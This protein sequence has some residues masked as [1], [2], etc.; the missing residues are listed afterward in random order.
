MK[1]TRKLTITSDEFFDYLENQL[2]KIANE[3]LEDQEAYT[4]SDIQEGFQI[5]QSTNTEVNKVELFINKY[6]RGSE[7]AA[8]AT[9]LTDSY[10]MSYQVKP[11]SD[12]IEVVY[13]QINLTNPSPAKSGFFAKFGE[14]L[15]LSRMSNSLYDVQN[16]IIKSRTH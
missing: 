6:I 16:A 4:N 2:L 12:G 10:S 8:T 15:Y 9:S 14:A 13:E 1:I 11:V 5:I 7:Y 3:N